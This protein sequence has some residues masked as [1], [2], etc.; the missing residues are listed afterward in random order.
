MLIVSV[1]RRYQTDNILGFSPFPNFRT[2]G[3]NSLASLG[4]LALIEREAPWPSELGI[5]FGSV[6]QLHVLLESAG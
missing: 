2:C 1:V 6:S 4:P 3:S 5:G